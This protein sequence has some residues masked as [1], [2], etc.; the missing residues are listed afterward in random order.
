MSSEVSGALSNGNRFRATSYMVEVTS[1]DGDV[2]ETVDI[3]DMVSVTRS[4]QTV[5]IQRRDGSTTE[6]TGASLDDAG[7][8]EATLRPHLAT[9]AEAAGA[10]GQQDKPGQGWRIATLIV[11]LVLMT[12]VFFQSCAASV[13]GS[14]SDD[15]DLS[16]AAGLGILV[17]FLFLFGGAFVLPFPRVSMVLFAVAAAFAL[18]GGV[19]SEFTDLIVWAV[20]ALGLGAMSYM[21]YRA[22][23]KARQAA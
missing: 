9:G 22:R 21:G 11:S 15:E 16:G 20:I 4:G 13:G 14:L 8:L 3:N 7:R 6:L 17:G 23:R 2:L 5:T 10:A 19:S 12:A 18:I 1:P